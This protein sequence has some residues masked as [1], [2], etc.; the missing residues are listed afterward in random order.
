MDTE[1][2]AES[3]EVSD[4]GAY[5]ALGG[6]GADCNFFI[7]FMFLLFPIFHGVGG[8]GAVVGKFEISQ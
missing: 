2:W 5:G 1:F 6:G 8:V 7:S 4:S 3:L